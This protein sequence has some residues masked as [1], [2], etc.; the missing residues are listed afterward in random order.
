MSPRIEINLSLSAVMADCKVRAPVLLLQVLRGQTSWK[1]EQALNR[2]LFAQSSKSMVFQRKEN[3]SFA[4]YQGG[5]DLNNRKG[6][7]A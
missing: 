1:P 7:A 3:K 2:P 6:R 5:G 4:L